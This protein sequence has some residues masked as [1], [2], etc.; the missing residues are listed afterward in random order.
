MG[1]PGREVTFS[2]QLSRAGS[3]G[4]V[5]RESGITVDYSR[6][7]KKRADY[8]WLTQ[9]LRKDGTCYIFTAQD[10]SR[11]GTWTRDVN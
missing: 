7:R 8:S 9:A 2:P 5:H 4:L 10:T 11:T 3:F 1:L 6:R